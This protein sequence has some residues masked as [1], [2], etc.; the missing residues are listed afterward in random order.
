MYTSLPHDGHAVL[1]SINSI[2]DFAEVILAQ[3]LILLREGAVVT[4]SQLKIVS[5]GV[6]IMLVIGCLI[7][8][9]YYYFALN[10][11]RFQR[12]FFTAFNNIS[13]FKLLIV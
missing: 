5:D 11:F 2:G 12:H 3:V 9:N 13:V 7:H 1:Y 10:N 6:K 8:I 4:A